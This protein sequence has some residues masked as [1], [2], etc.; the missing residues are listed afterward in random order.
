MRDGDK[1]IEKVSLE[2][3]KIMDLKN[4]NDFV[5]EI[6]DIGSLD[7]K[8]K[9]R[10]EKIKKILQEK[11]IEYT[12]EDAELFDGILE[13][14]KSKKY[15]LDNSQLEKIIAGV[16]NYNDGRELPPLTAEDLPDDLKE[17]L[18]IP[19]R[20]S[21]IKLILITGLACLV[22]G[23]VIGGGISYFMEKNKKDKED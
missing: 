8:K 22:G 4:D 20:R 2:E 3:Q 23:A 5:K 14:L 10:F 16:S 12:K 21:R 19:T 7:I 1:E 11:G 9:E 18:H 15:K 17:K 13:L 6:S